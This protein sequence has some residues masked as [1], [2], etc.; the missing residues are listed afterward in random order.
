[1][2]ACM[3]VSKEV[4]TDDDNI[5]LITP[6]GSSGSKGT[7][8]SSIQPKTGADADVAAS[9]LDGQAGSEHG[10]STVRSYSN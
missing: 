10:E 4:R 2:Y 3:H 9:R 8:G 7:Q 6:N 1:M 5:V